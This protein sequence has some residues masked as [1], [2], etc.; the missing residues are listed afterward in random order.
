MK[1]RKNSASIRT[2]LTRTAA[3]LAWVAMSLLLS[4]GRAQHSGEPKRVLVLY[5]YNKDHF[6][7][8][9]FDQGFQAAV[10]SAAG[11]T[12]EYYSEY[13][14]SNRF[15]G[16][17]Q[18]LLLRN[19]LRQKYADRTIHV[20]VA[21]S[22]ASLDFL[23]K[24]R[25]DLFPHTPIVFVAVRHP[26]TEDLAAAP[27]ATG[28]ININA[29]RKTLD[30]ALRFHPRTEQVFVISGTL[31][32]DKKFE[33]PARQDLQGY[34]S[35][36]PLR[37]LT[38]LQPDELIAQMKGLP[39]RSIVLYIWQQSQNKQGGVME[40][41]DLLALIAQSAQVP[42]YLLTHADFDSGIVGGYV[43][44]PGLMAPR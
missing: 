35:R 21:S 1:A 26:T 41:A 31:Q 15:P 3:L 17:N 10:Q 6:W 42:I 28:I 16:E 18:S 34:E 11:G 43:S 2:N 38:D 7:N 29:Y 20:L 37:Y 23:F 30:L 36:V 12:V 4:F 22:D 25:N 44:T 14:E 8:V 33:T 13:L 5:W 19:Y 39:K 40:S 24:Y 27:G 9:G 32:H